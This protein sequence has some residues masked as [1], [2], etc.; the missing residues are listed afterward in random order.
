MFVVYTDVDEID[1]RVG[2]YK[3]VYVCMYS[4]ASLS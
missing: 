2:V 4:R 1:G 3:G